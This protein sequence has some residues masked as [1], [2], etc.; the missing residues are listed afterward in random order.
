MKT[1]SKI[2]ILLNLAFVLAYFVYAIRQKENILHNGKLVKLEL[3]PADPRSL[4]Q[5]DYMALNYK[6]AN[7]FFRFGQKKRYDSIPAR[8]YAVLSL[9]ENQVA[10][11]LRLQKDKT[12]LSPG[13]T[14]MEFNKNRFSISIGAESFFFQEG[15]SKQYEHAK[16]GLIRVDEA[17]RSVLVGVE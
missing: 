7:K 5:G 4:M 1:Y 14:L 8:G 6:E 11:I 12:P 16:Y 3:A 10:T 15:K 17:G 2:L 13:E 9:H